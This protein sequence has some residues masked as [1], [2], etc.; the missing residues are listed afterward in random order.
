MKLRKAIRLFIIGFIVL[1]ILAVFLN[2]GMNYFINNELPKIINEKND[3]DYTFEYKSVDFSIFNNTLILNQI[4]IIPKPFNN[5]TKNYHYQTKINNIHISGVDF[6]KLV[7]SKDL[8]ANTIQINEPEV[9]IYKIAFKE[10]EENLESN[11]PKSINIEKIVLEKANIKVI[12]VEKNTVIS[13]V[14]NLDI[15]IDVLKMGDYTKSKD[16]PFTYKNYEIKFDSIFFKL[17]DFEYVKSNKVHIDNSSFEVDNFRITPTKESFTQSQQ[18]SKIE[19]VVPKISITGS[20][21]EIKNSNFYLNISNIDIDSVKFEVLSKKIK[22]T[23]QQNNTNFI[24]EKFLPFHLNVK[25]LNIKNSSFK[26]FDTFNFNQVNL[27][28][29]GIT[30]QT[31][32]QLQIEEIVLNNPIINQNSNKESGQIKQSRTNFLMYNLLIKNFKINNA[33]YTKQNLNGKNELTVNHLNLSLTQININSET[34]RNKI[35]FTYEGFEAKTGKIYYNTGKIYDL[36]IAETKILNK[37]VT[38]SKLSL[39]SK[40]TRKD[41]DSQLKYGTDLYNLNADQIVL[42]GLDFGFDSNE[43]FFLSSNQLDI[44]QLNANIYRNASIPNAPF[45]KKIYSQKLRGLKFGLDIPK[46]NIKNSTLIYQEVS[47]K[48]LEIG[49]LTFNNFNANIKNIYSGYARKTG[50]KTEIKVNTNFMKQANVNVLW[51]FNILNKSD[52][53]NIQGTVKNLPAEAMNPF[54]KPYL[55]VSGTGIIDEVDFNFNGDNNKANGT[56]AMNYENLKISLFKEKDNEM[57]KRAFLSDLANLAIKKN[58]HGKTI[59]HHTKT[60]E[61]EKNKGF[62]NFFWLNLKQ[63]LQ[64]TLLLI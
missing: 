33:K 18:S 57:K 42:Q 49:T 5:Q 28:F 11:L 47:K 35:P 14:A 45:T 6:L 56:F 23:N 63:G 16:L 62:F 29:K 32:N 9:V 61:R 36:N 24:K 43:V 19:I 25:E 26:L 41:F 13:K 51:T 52:A 38:I 54:L 22:L 4:K 30:N 60:V 27:Q 37:T 64:Q 17:N 46:I 59:E 55:N 40:L 58:T 3:T 2:L 15:K 53:F 21:W 20:D 7:F 44:N 10:K 39:K 48:N 31:S 1:G 12:D 50:P 34:L 8:K